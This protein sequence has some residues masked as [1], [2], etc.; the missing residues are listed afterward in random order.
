VPQNVNNSSFIQFSAPIS[1]GSGGG[2]VLNTLGQVVGVSCLTVLSG[3][4]LNFA[5][6]INAMKELS[7]TGAVPL[8]T[9]VAKNADATIYYRSYFPVPDYGVYVG[10]PIYRASQDKNTGVKTYYYRLSDITAPDSVAVDGYVALLTE[11]GFKWQSSYKNDAGKTV[12][13]YKNADFGMSVHFGTDNFNGIACRFVAIYRNSGAVKQGA[14][15]SRNLPG[16]RHGFPGR[17]SSEVCL[18]QK[19]F[20]SDG[21]AIP[22]EFYTPNFSAGHIAW[23]LS[24]L[25]FIPARRPHLQDTAGSGTATVPPALA[26]TAL[27]CEVSRCRQG[28]SARSTCVTRCLSSCA[29][30]PSSSICRRLASAQ[31][32][33]EGILLRAVHA[34]RFRGDGD[35][36]WY[37]PFLS[38]GYLRASLMHTLLVSS[39]PCSSC[40]ETASS[41]TGGVSG[42]IAPVRRN[43]RG[44][45]D[46]QQLSEEQLYVPVLCDADTALVIFQTWFGNPGYMVPEFFV[47]LLI[48]ASSMFRES[49]P[50]GATA[51]GPCNLPTQR[52]IKLG[53]PRTRS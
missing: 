43:D 25:L 22:S 3:Q 15:I 32:A 19:Y 42:S 49:S 9:I 39:C 53:V 20:W 34:G 24:V 40:G 11:N 14:P 30:S 4:T 41:R 8:I 46:G 50:V 6:P 38:F 51:S 44:G 7:R 5:V 52:G 27:L 1:M 18:M 10:T 16:R 35:A 28:S 23:V 13:V 29:A 33:P 12:D 45:F 48:W 17:C 47:L 36:G 2:P 21:S 26:V 37:F 31:P